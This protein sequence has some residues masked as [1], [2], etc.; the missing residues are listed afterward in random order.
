MAAVLLG[1]TLALTPAHNASVDAVLYAG[2]G[3]GVKAGVEIGPVVL[4][5]ILNQLIMS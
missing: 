3:A 1:Q 4:R 2:F 5:R